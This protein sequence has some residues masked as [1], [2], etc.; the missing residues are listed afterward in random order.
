MLALNADRTGPTVV[1]DESSNI[2][3][4]RV[5][6]SNYSLVFF[7]TQKN[8]GSTGVTVAV[9]KKS[10][11]SP[12]TTQPSPALMQKRGLP[13]PPI[14]LQYETIAKN[15]GLYNTLSILLSPTRRSESC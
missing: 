6:V 4:R 11:L 10:F 5:P 14:T 2:L 1:T 15:N 12:V 9:F 3:S 7:G 8:L 13:I